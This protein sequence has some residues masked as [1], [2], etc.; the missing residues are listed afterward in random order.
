MRQCQCD[1]DSF[2]Q[3]QIYVIVLLTSCY[4]SARV[5]L[6]QSLFHFQMIRNLTVNYCTSTAVTAMSSFCF[7]Q[8]EVLHIVHDTA[9]CL[10]SNLLEKLRLFHL[11]PCIISFLL[12]PLLTFL[13]ERSAS[14]FK[15]ITIKHSLTS[16]CRP[17]SNG[18]EALRPTRATGRSLRGSRLPGQ[19]T[20]KQLRCLGGK[21][22]EIG[23]RGH[24]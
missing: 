10:K 11:S 4:I 21:S 12:S 24:P 18:S 13:E 19:A 6:Y 17:L 8:I 23:Y 1:L 16:R 22:D 9:T 20:V 2:L 5:S 3:Y 15:Y 14:R 7:Q